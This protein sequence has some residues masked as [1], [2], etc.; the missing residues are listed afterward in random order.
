MICVAVQ[1]KSV[2]ECVELTRNAELVELRIDLCE[3]DSAQVADFM[4]K[5]QCP[6]LATARHDDMGLEK[7]AELLKTAI[8][9]GAKY[10]DIEIEVPEKERSALVDY[11]KAKGCDVIISYHNY[12][13]TPSTEEMKTILQD[14]YNYGADVAKLAVQNNSKEDAARTIGLHALG[15]RIVVLGMGKEGVIS[16][17]AAPLLGS[18][19]TFA[20]ATPELA[21][22]PGQISKEAL[23]TIYKNI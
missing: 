10:I 6:I 1:N 5:A 8:D 9:A 14:C 22:A 15:G 20:S 18:E 21:T 4:A 11:A 13:S 16:R 7:Q 19:F 2:D 12:D 23:Q 17:V 3:F